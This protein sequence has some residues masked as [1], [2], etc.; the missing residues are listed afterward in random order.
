MKRL[1]EKSKN[2]NIHFSNDRLKRFKNILVL[3]AVPI[4]FTFIFGMVYSKVYV[5]KIPIA[6]LDMDHTH[7][8]REVIKGFEKSRGFTIAYYADS[9]EEL[10]T[11]IKEKTAY[12]GL[13]I[14]NDFQKNLNDLQSPSVLLLVDE[15]NIVI[16]NN[17]LSYGNK[18]L[19][20]MN[21]KMQLNILEQKGMT[22]YIAEQ[23]IKSLSFVERMLYD[24]QMN[25]MKYVFMG[26]LGIFIQQTFLGVV[27]PILIEE[28]ERLSR[29]RLTSKTNRST[30]YRFM[31][32]I[33]AIMILT[34]VSSAFCLYIARVWFGH[35]LR[36]SILYTVLIQVIFLLDITAIALILASIFNNI[37]HCVQFLMLL[38]IPTLLTSGYVWPEFMMPKGFGVIIK[39]AWPLIYYVNPMRYLQIKGAGLDVLAPYILGGLIFAL[40]WLPIGM[41][42]YIRKIKNEKK[43]TIM[44][45]M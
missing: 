4:I 21:L 41:L 27:A 8:S 18:I 37:A 24:P 43:N 15:S 17:A 14:P 32:R 26:L 22:P 16:G 34:F 40:I 23:S 35:P 5:E 12:S 20:T 11:I 39:M 29:I 1:I 3:V 36:G 45:D 38:S 13:I 2:L 30:L 44:L 42:L 9:Y 25:Y 6:I 28:R 33:L 10:E 31:G 7:I 19:N